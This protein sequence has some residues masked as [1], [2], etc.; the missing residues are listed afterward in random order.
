[1]GALVNKWQFD[2]ILSAQ[3]GFPVSLNTSY[4]YNCAHGFTP[5]GGP[6]LSHYLYNDYSN[7]TKLG[8]FTA[9]PEYQLKNLPD[10]LTSLRQP[11]MP[12]LDAT[13]QKTFS[14]AERYNVTFR[15]DAFNLTNSVLFPGPDSNP[16]DGPPV[17][18][19]KSCTGFGTV[20]LNQLNFPRILQFA[21]KVT[22]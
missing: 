20:T 9:I 14:V 6:S 10:R 11:T 8:C 22:F 16:N 3:A 12:N 4:Y 1:L 17:C 15:A 21:L 2:S 5:N 19:G 7:G 13:L 18:N